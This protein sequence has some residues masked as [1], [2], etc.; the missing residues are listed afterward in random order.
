MSLF[1]DRQV[2][3]SFVLHDLGN[4][5]WVFVDSADADVPTLPAST[6][7][8][9]SSLYALESGVV[10]GPDEV[11][12]W[13]GTDHGR[14]EVN[15]D[16]TLREALHVS[17][18]W[19]HRDIARRAGSQVLKHWLDTVGYGNADTSGGFDKAWIAGGLRITPREQVRFLERLVRSE[20]PFSARTVETV[21]RMALLE[22]T[23]GHALYGKTGW[24][25][26]GEGTGHAGE[27]I[28]WFVGWVEKKDGS[29]PFVFA[30]RCR[31]PVAEASR[32][33]PA[34][35]AI[36]MA[37]LERLGILSPNPA[38]HGR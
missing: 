7:K 19:V 11:F 36:S 23:L 6:F 29:G 17:A 37:M 10:I 2:S 16:L 35:R 32:L 5:H 22:D 31:A 13:D 38:H 27:D 24:A 30:C 8:L 18:Y 34:R 3:G 1:A 25:S 33:G 21:K 4:D 12:T 14:P 28:G 26:S 15:K 20:L 9:F